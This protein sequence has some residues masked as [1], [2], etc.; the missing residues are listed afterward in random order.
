MLLRSI[1]PFFLLFF[2]LGPAI[3][4][5]QKPFFRAFSFPEEYRD[6]Q[7]DE[8]FLSSAG[9]IWIGADGGLFRFD[10]HLALPVQAPGI[11]GPFSVSSIFED[12][13]GVLWIGLE[14]GSIYYMDA[15]EKLHLWEPEEGLPTV[16]VTAM[17]QDPAGNFWF[18]TYGEGLYCLKGKRLYHFGEDDGLSGDEIY[19]M[20]I[21]SFGYVWCGTDRGIDVV[22]WEGD[23][24]SI[25]RIGLEEGLPDEI[26]RFLVSDEHCGIWVGMHDG[27]LCRI[28]PKTRKVEFMVSDWDLGP[29]TSIACF[30]NKEVW[31][32]TEGKGLFR[33][34]MPSGNLE[35]LSPPNNRPGKKIHALLRDT[36]GGVWIASNAPGFYAA[37]RQFEVVSRSPEDIQAVLADQHGG[38][39]L[40]AQKGLFHKPAYRDTFLLILPK[41]GLNVISLFEDH[42]DNIWIGT[43]GDGLYCYRKKDGKFIHIGEGP[44]LGNGSI[45]SIGGKD[46]TLWLS[47]LAGVNELTLEGDPLKGGVIRSKSYNQ[48]SGLGSNYIY[49]VMVDSR[50]R[51]WFC[52]DGKGLSVLEDGVFTT[53]THADSIPLKAVYS[54]AED[55]KG[56]IW[57]STRDQGIFKFDGKNFTGLTLK[58]GLR[59]L[60]ISGLAATY[61]GQ[62]LVIHRS[63]IDL[64]TPETGHLIYYDAEVGVPDAEPNLN[65]MDSDGK[66]NVWIGMP[67]HLIRFTTLEQPLRIHPETRLEKVSVMLAPV[68][69]W[70]KSEF[71]HRENF[72][73]FDFVGIWLTDPESVT[74]RYKL[75]G[76]DQDWNYARD[77]RKTY[78]HLPPGNY[79]FHLS[80]SENGAWLDE[81]IMS[82]HFKIRAPLWQRPWFM[83]LSII[84][85]AAL[86]Y[87]LIKN[88]ETR[89]R[90]IE[91]LKRDSIRSQY[92]TLKSQ[93]NPHFLFNSFN[94]LL[95]FIE[96]D[97][98]L[99][100]EYVEKLSDFYR[101]ILAYREMEKIP[102]EEELNLTENFAYL[103][104]KR[105][106]E[107][108]SLDIRVDSRS[109]Y[110]V[111]PLALQMLVE[112]AVKHNVVGKSKPLKVSIER[113]E[114]DYLLVTNNLQPK[115]TADPSTGF[116]LSGIVNRYAMLTDRPVLVEKTENEFRVKV[117]LLK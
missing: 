77:R 47:T 75:E 92:E 33:L 87:Y 19:D 100:A 36:E 59:N 62:L 106:G 86:S 85:L 81:P 109:N 7:I 14:N 2:A 79:A 93:I 97:P 15:S 73:A 108:F 32:G 70:E 52:T 44:L 115:M 42:Y 38:V 28:D 84:G 83:A 74:Y 64:L 112:N 89:M 5:A 80:S 50:G 95:A 21:D 99:A 34:D 117:P 45:L 39:W 43:Y 65:A 35:N 103:L 18:S 63:G 60:S 9:Y 54:I 30:H 68:N 23:K 27:G 94:T 1:Y 53:Y 105:F 31:I 29:V 26:V 13:K 58:Q 111:A 102:L 49:R 72:L 48:E 98:A 107:N 61:D 8:L 22:G 90:R 51:T 76:Y 20:T 96:E 56:N 101:V 4:L 41:L 88:R 113:L 91:K 37:N 69:W 46:N 55:G 12:N 82:Y 66:G 6:V 67:G 10:G 40:G 71:G 110:F 114:G 24:K 3:T 25:T 16:A 17:A 11:K 57:F 78:S 104:K 116:G